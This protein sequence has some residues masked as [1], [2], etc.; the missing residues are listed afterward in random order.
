MATPSELLTREGVWSCRA[1]SRGETLS[2]GYLANNPNDRNPENAARVILA[3]HERHAL[4]MA[5]RQRRMKV[6]VLARIVGVHPN[7]IMQW[8]GG[9]RRPMPEDLQRW[10]D[11]VL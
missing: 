3:A 7:T 6:K 4:R 2:N 8:Q 1:D 10:R 5:R 11:A 9:R